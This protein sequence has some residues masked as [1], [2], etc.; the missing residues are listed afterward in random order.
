MLA[1]KDSIE[2]LKLHIGNL[3]WTY[4]D[5]L[6]DRASLLDDLKMSNSTLDLHYFGFKHLAD[7][8]SSLRSQLDEQG[9]AFKIELKL[10]S[11]KFLV[12]LDEA[13]KCALQ[14][15]TEET[16][17]N[18]LLKKS[19]KQ[20]VNLI[21]ENEQLRKV[22][23]ENSLGHESPELKQ[24]REDNQIL[25]SFLQEV[26]QQ[27][28]QVKVLYAE[29]EKE[30]ALLKEEVALLAS[31]KN[32]AMECVNKKLLEIVTSVDAVK[33]QRDGQRESFFARREKKTSSKKHKHKKSRKPA[34]KNRPSLSSDMRSGRS[35]EAPSP[36]SSPNS[37]CTSNQS[38]V[39]VGAK[40]YRANRSHSFNDLAASADESRPAHPDRDADNAMPR[41]PAQY[42]S[43]RM[44][45][46]LG[47]KRR[48]SVVDLPKPAATLSDVENR[49][50][51][52]V[53]FR[54]APKK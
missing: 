1:L 23:V 31:M 13:R 51:E 21:H 20:N 7:E 24:A 8:N 28:E 3:Q 4:E 27:Y 37:S 25:Q 5:S 48:K 42:E 49:K 16:R 50:R 54:V 36:S 29:K 33:R 46:D 15:Q 22:V 40:S 26:R 6:A 43:V 9:L 38:A 14:H 32:N 34:K 2:K 18:C 35:K 19:Q 45:F 41:A 52:L 10:N 17:L 39:S 12:R 11:E 53:K 44:K 47:K 30:C